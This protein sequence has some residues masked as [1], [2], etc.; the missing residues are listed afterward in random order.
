MDSCAE[1]VHQES[2]KR[3]L[4]SRNNGFV[5]FELVGDETIPVMFDRQVS[6]HADKPA[7]VS[8]GSQITYAEL[9]R[10]SLKIACGVCEHVGD[11]GLLVAFLITNYIHFVASTLGV[12]RCAG[13]YVPLDPS[14]PEDRNA[15]ILQ[16]SRARYILTERAH[17]GLAERLVLPGQKLIY[18]DEMAGE[19]DRHLSD[20]SHSGALACLI[21]TSGSTGQPKGVKQTHSN[22]L[23]IVRRYTHGLY[24]GFQDRVALLSSC[25]VT[26]SIGT[27][28]GSLLNGATLCALSVKEEGLDKLAD[29]LDAERISVYRSVPSLFR[30]LMD[31]VAPHR[32]FPSVQIVRLG[33]DSLHKR[34]WEL[35]KQ[36]FAPEAA[37]INFYGCSEMSTA[38]RFYM[39][40]SS[41][42]DD[43]VLPV[44]FALDDVEIAVIDSNGFERSVSADEA[45]VAAGS[46]FTGEIVLRSRHLSPGY[47]NDSAATDA[48]FTSDDRNG[49]D[50]R[51]YR[52]GDMGVLRGGQGLVHVGRADFQVKVSGFRVEIAEVEACL[53]SYPGVKEA[54]VVLHSPEH[55]ERALMGFVVMESGDTHCGP[56]IRLHVQARLPAHMAPSDVLAVEQIPYTPNGKIDRAAL[57]SIREVA[58]RTRARLVPRT[59]TEEALSE[60][61]RQVLNVDEVGVEDNFFELGGN[62]LLGM[63]LAAGTAKR[64]AV[65]FRI[66][67]VFQHPTI[68]Q[69][70]QLIDGLLR[71][72]RQSSPASQELEE[73]SV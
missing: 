38:A 35:Y 22:I 37:L 39:D 34:D 61:W 2:I 28:F 9:D 27:I 70:A 66:L 1:G 41:Q 56:S 32:I 26:A 19:E 3:R 55:G 10:L 23:Q 12:L 48:A 21:F 42:L 14:F 72:G 49:S 52:T 24:L 18:V 65:P 25:S 17:Q 16:E 33:G 30:H 50:M 58:W 71:D 29:W 63:K 62:S 46:V 59:H 47:W 45:Q 8:M 60:I 44:G 20:R 54:A 11:D 31:S 69:M 73:G 64:F 36:H 4:L 43:G 6:R 68:V 7:I 13:F 40:A 51:V 15:R 67:V 53:R 57:I 5:G